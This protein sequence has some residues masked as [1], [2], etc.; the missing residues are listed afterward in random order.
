M[1]RA[2]IATEMITC[3]ATPIPTELLSHSLFPPTVT[4][5]GD[6]KLPG[7]SEL[8]LAPDN[9]GTCGHI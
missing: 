2:T 3:T 8:L 4:V 6:E 9:G 5:T 1:S 7:P